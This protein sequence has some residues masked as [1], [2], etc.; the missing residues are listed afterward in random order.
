MPILRSFKSGNT[1]SWVATDVA[2]FG[3]EI[4]H[5]AHV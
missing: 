3:L 4:P 2:A 1:L 5:V